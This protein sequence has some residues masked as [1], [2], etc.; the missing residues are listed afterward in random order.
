[1]TEERRRRVLEN[2][3]KDKE[4]LAQVPAVVALSFGVLPVKRLGTVLTVACFPRVN[5]DVLRLLRAV[6]ELEIVALPV[7]ERPLQTALQ[8]AYHQEDDKSPNFPTFR[9]PDFVTSPEAAQALRRE[10]VETLGRTGASLEPGLVALASWSYRSCLWNLDHP[11]L[12]GAL[13]DP[14]AL[15]YELRDEPLAWT[16]DAAGSPVAWVSEE[17]ARLREDDVLLLDE[18][19][20]SDHRHV[21]AGALFAEHR[22]GGVRL[23]AAD[24]PHVIHPTEV[25]LV[26][27]E[28]GGELVFH[29]YDHE[30]R[31]APGAAG[32]LR[33]EYHFLSFGSRLR[34]EIVVSIEEL[35]V[36]ERATLP[37][38]A[39]TPP[40]GR[41]DL[42]RW[43][44]APPT[45][46]SLAP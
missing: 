38:R 16:R 35:A 11:R 15:R 42:A 26:R 20:L 5:R 14:R 24:L 34:R 6:L 37:V 1:M 39:G 30:E 17:P 4:L 31:V 2:A 25:Q 12:G 8:K 46:P 23:R 9:E 33:C 3:L 32:E 43:F 7:D 40:W 44:D 13:P 29:V 36:H 19:K 22:V 41:R 28:R 27:V 10:K 45:R 21:A 18:V